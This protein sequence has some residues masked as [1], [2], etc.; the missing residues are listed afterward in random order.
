MCVRTWDEQLGFRIQ[1][2]ECKFVYVSSALTFLITGY[3]LPCCDDTNLDILLLF[4]LETLILALHIHCYS[5]FSTSTRISNELE[6]S[7]E[8]HVPNTCSCQSSLSSWHFSHKRCSLDSY[9]SNRVLTVCVWTKS[10]SIQSSDGPRLPSLW[11][12]CTS[13]WWS[14]SICWSTNCSWT[15]CRCHTRKRT[16]VVCSSVLFVWC[17]VLQSKVCLLHWLLLEVRSTVV[18]LSHLIRAPTTREHN[19]TVTQKEKMRSYALRCFLHRVLFSKVEFVLSLV[20][21]ASAFVWVHWHCQ[22]IQYE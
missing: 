11:S 12:P 13:T 18:M 20:R 17:V 7:H 9:T 15:Q 14:H 5:L 16:A 19:V 10:S 21:L 8:S 4:S 1:M 22:G 6:R 2:G 3:T